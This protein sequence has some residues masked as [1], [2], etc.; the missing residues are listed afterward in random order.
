MLKAALRPQPIDLGDSSLNASLDKFFVVEGI[1]A[2]GKRPPVH[3][4]SSMEELRFMGAG[5]VSQ[6][7]RDRRQET[8]D[9]VSQRHCGCKSEEGRNLV[10][11]NIR[12]N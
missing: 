9:H 6:S 10:P 12:G 1:L 5:W 3:G 7:E 2:V 4:L 8:D 11:Q